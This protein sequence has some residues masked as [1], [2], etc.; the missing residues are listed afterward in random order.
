MRV[1][2]EEEEPEEEKEEEG[3]KGEVT[4]REDNKAENEIQVL[5]ADKTAWL[6]KPVH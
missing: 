4:E 2:W 3:E 1:K 6:K 5:A